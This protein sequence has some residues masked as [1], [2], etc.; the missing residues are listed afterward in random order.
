[1]NTQK[2]K[3]PNSKSEDSNDSL[4]SLFPPI[5]SS[6][7][8][9][10][11]G[12]GSS[13]LQQ[14]DLCFALPTWV[15]SST[16]GLSFRPPLDKGFV[17]GMTRVSNS[18]GSFPCVTGTELIC[19]PPAPI[20]FS[21]VLHPIFH[22]PARSYFSQIDS[23]LRKTNPYLPEPDLPLP[24]LFS[25]ARVAPNRGEAARLQSR[26]SR[27]KRDFSTRTITRFQVRGTTE[28]DDAE[29]GERDEEEI[30]NRCSGFSFPF[31]NQFRERQGFVQQTSF[32]RYAT[33]STLTVS[34]RDE[35]STSYRQREGRDREERETS[36][37]L[38]NRGWR[39]GF[40]EK[41]IA[42]GAGDELWQRKLSSGFAEEEMRGRREKRE[43]LL[44]SDLCN[45]GDVYF[46]V[47]FSFPSV[48]YIPCLTSVG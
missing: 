20:S 25:G 31:Q 29:V 27:S 41:E 42:S 23:A 16:R 2:Q 34:K 35:E 4:L 32:G 46:W 5:T 7:S 40:V 9:V 33:K 24:L 30:G 48:K 3:L 6:I 36:L 12:L 26:F 13:G 11:S 1:M 45:L 28:I 19:C 21:P 38:A 18:T 44:S 14:R 43:S 22:L 8:I 47:S 10:F 15:S 17:P 39:R 37:L